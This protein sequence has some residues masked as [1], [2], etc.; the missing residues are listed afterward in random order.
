[1]AEPA[2]APS[3]AGAEK[4]AAAVASSASQPAAAAVSAAQ[5]KDPM[6]ATRIAVSSAGL[7]ALA[8]GTAALEYY[9]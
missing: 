6:E 3:S 7:G 1:M 8:L 4:A 5:A 9:F 2:A